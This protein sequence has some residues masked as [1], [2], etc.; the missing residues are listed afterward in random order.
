MYLVGLGTNEDV[1][2]KSSGFLFGRL[3]EG[4]LK[5]FFISG[6]SSVLSGGKWQYSKYYF[7]DTIVANSAV[8]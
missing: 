6:G 4:Q 5:L 3:R 7:R 2:F 1:L 8:M